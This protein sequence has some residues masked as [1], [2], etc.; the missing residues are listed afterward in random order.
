MTR[1]A[2]PGRA[3]QGLILS[4]PVAL[5]S[6]GTATDAAY[7]RTA[8]I[9]WSNF[10]SWAIVGGLMFGGAAFVWSLIDL[11][12]GRRGV[13]RFLYS[14]A[15]GA[16][17]VVGLT[18]AFKHSQDGWSSVGAFGFTL[19]VLCC[20]LALSAGWMRYSGMLDEEASR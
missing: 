17:C 12:W 5:F 19:S 11:A 10:S 20:A 6:L 8:E 15:L 13:L 7:L 3:V 2:G 4:F 14:G 9:Q 16:L 1:A 18:N